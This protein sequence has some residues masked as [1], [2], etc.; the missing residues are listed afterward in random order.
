M[1]RLRAERR[2]R[3]GVL[4][5]ASLCSGKTNADDAVLSREF[6]FEEAPFAACHASTIAETHGGLVAAWFGGTKEGNRDVGIWLARKEGNAWSKPVKVAD[7]QDDAGMR[8]PCWNP[9]LY[10]HKD[11]LLLLFYKVGPAPSRWWGVMTDSTDSG[12]TWSLPRR[13]P[14][15][16]LGPIKNK[17]VALADGSLLCPSSTEDHG[18]RAHM[19]RT[20]DLGAHWTKT[21][22]LNDGKE[23]AIIQPTILVH[24]N[25]QLQ[26]LCRSQQGSIMESWSNDAGKTWSPLTP[27]SLPNPNSGIDAVTLTDGRF[28]L[29]YNHARNRRTPLNIALSVDGKS[30]KAGPVLEQEQ[31]EFSYPAVIQTADGLVHITYTWKRKRIA[32]VVVDPGKLTTHQVPSGAKDRPQLAE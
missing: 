21:E 28:L 14:E 30:W 2:T 31:G 7:G 27:T 20:N 18:D 29:V 10:Q 17:P 4:L 3:F 26:I 22:P 6:I 23:F 9:V 25:T 12:K 16:F 13:L 24:S 5:F 11:G 32:H 15:G 1:I 8:Y 19:E